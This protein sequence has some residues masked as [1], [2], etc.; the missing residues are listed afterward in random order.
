MIYAQGTISL[1]SGSA[2]ARGTGT[3]FKDNINGIAPGQIIVIQSGSSNLL[4]MIQAV[5]S[6]TELVLADKATVTLSNA[7]Y[8]IQTTVPDSISDGVRRMVAANSYIIQFLQNMDK[9]MSQ[10]GTV[11]VTLP[12]GQ[13]V[14]LQSIR[15]LQAAL[16][17]KADK[18]E[19]QQAIRALQAAMDGKLDKSGGI[20]TGELDAQRISSRVG[21]KRYM[22]GVRDNGQ[23]FLDYWDGAKWLGEVLHPHQGGTMA[24]A[25]KTVT[26]QG[27]NLSTR[28]INAFL[29]PD[30]YYQPAGAEATDDRG[31]PVQQFGLL[32]VLPSDYRGGYVIQ[33]YTAG[34]SG[35]TFVRKYTDLG[36]SPWSC[37][38]KADISTGLKRVTVDGSGFVKKASPII[39]IHPSGNFDTNDESEGAIVSKLGTGHYQITGVL[40]YNA[41]GAWGVHGGISSPKNNNGLELI[42]I[43]DTVNKDGSITIETFH[44]QHA[45]LP[46]RFQNKRIKAIIDG[47]KVYYKDGESCDIPE[48]CR[49][50]VRVQMPESLVWNLS[51]GE[52]EVEND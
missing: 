22:L 18:A 32:E 48:G 15:A 46:D 28:S 43:D 8:Q 19:S 49:L 4:H 51:Q 42:Y 31:Y 33:R 7:T 23:A 41:D 36:G 26:S 44:R 17:G 10:N 39:Q 11:E 6:D 38:I 29:K 45:H 34:H 2:I 25:E 27:I 3:R 21:N 20:A 47:E 24:L 14:T 9:W 52:V 16:E 40:G 35:D 30:Y 37:F 50:D 1:V 12:N 13:V 5:N